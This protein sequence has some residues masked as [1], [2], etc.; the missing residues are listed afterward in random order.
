VNVT[1]ILPTIRPE[2]ASRCIAAIPADVRVICRVDAARIGCPLM[3]ADMVTEVKTEWVCFLADDTVPDPCMLANAARC[4]NLVGGGF[5]ALNDG[6]HNGRVAT[7]WVARMDLL[8]R[9]GGYFFHPDYKHNWCDV[10]LSDIMRYLGEYA[11]ARDAKMRHL[12]PVLGYE[13]DADYERC[14]ALS[15]QDRQTYV[16]RRASRRIVIKAN[17]APHTG[18]VAPS[19]Q[20]L[21]GRSDHV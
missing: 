16:R 18:A 4:A 9:I 8:P 21:V 11:Y 20:A 12:H 7:H 10:E 17:A 15:E 14:M 19:V 5:I 3:V 2:G 1:V 13:L 6:I